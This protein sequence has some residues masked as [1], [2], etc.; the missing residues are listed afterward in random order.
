MRT[1]SELLRQLTEIKRQIEHSED[2]IDA[3][4][5]LVASLT[6][7]GHEATQAGMLLDSF[8]QSRKIW[9]G[10]MDRLL[11]ALDEM[12]REKDAA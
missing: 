10:E 3:Q 7:R 12:P 9:L 11:G 1:R 4:R 6:A 8:E 2:I 5:R